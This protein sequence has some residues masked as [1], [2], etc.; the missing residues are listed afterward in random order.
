MTDHV[1]GPD[2]PALPGDPS[3]A[4]LEHLLRGA[5]TARA[6]QIGHQ[7]LRPASPPVLLAS[8]R[9]GWLR[10]PA[11]VAAAAAVLALVAATATLWGPGA[12]PARP[13]VAASPAPGTTTGGQTGPIVMG[14]Q[15]PTAPGETVH[16]IHVT[17]GP[18]GRQRYT[19]TLT[20]RTEAVPGRNATVSY[21][22]A[23]VAGT[24]PVP[25]RRLA[26]TVNAR[27]GLLREGYRARLASLSGA[28]SPFTQAI[29][30]RTDG[31]WGRTVSIVLDDIEDNGTAIADGRTVAV[32]A[33]VSTGK[34]LT[35]T[36]LFTDVD[37][38]DALMRKAVLAAVGPGQVTPQ[39]LGRLS[40]RPGAHGSTRPPAWYPTAQGLHWTVDPQDLG[41]QV[42]DAVEAVVDWNRLAGLLAPGARG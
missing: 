30:F 16:T 18:G 1:P 7:D 41:P 14:P 23:T 27:I 6:G 40:M 31:R 24:D 29:R 26:A 38:V 34:A 10:P 13:P 33:D 9:P 22:L 39:A 36:D 21:P 25:A 17:V 11:L 4:E 37:A 42:Q 28:G 5:L 32:V 19:L 35:A 2:R 3:D 15:G 12:T 20:P 8:A